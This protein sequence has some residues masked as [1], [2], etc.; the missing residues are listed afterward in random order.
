MN[1]TTTAQ[2]TTVPAWVQHHYGGP[3]AVVLGHRPIP[4]PGPDEVLVQVHAT[5]LNAADARLMRGDP[6]L[7]RLGFGLARPKQ[8]VR[9][10][11]VAGRITAVG[12]GVSGFAVGD[13]IV[14]ETNGG[15]LAPL[16]VVPAKRLAHR[17]AGI[18]PRGAPVVPPAGGPALPA[19]D[20]AGVGPVGG[21][22]PRSP[23]CSRSRA[24]PP[25]RR[26]TSRGSA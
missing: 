15:G 21:T 3:D 8:P 22:R 24:A 6:Y 9:G 4:T 2:A 16:V 17:P 10:M 11:D 13:E 14:A 19:L 7:V 23:R 25:S 18:S 26:S 12:A 1:T 20:P 5:G